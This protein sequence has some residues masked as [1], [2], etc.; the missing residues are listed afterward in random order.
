[1]TST[2][3]YEGNLRTTMTH[4][5][6]GQTVTTDAPVDN[7]GKGEAFSPTDLFSTAWAS[8]MVTTMAIAAENRGWSIEGTHAEVTKVMSADLPRRIVGTDMI[9][10]MG[11]NQFSEEQKT[12]LERSART[13]PISKSVHPDVVEKIVFTWAS[14]Q[15]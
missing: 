4:L 2:I 13:C 6:S 14:H 11:E 12:I 15:A 10:Y 8:C 7:H 1:M 9:I 5:K 3:K